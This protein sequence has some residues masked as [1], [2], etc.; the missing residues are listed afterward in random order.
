MHD[1][2]AQLEEPATFYD[3]FLPLCD[4]RDY[5]SGSHHAENLQK[6]HTFPAPTFSYVPS[7]P[8]S[9]SGH[10][11]AT[12]T[13]TSATAAVLDSTAFRNPDAS[14][15]PTKRLEKRPLMV[16]PDHD[17]I[18]V[19]NEQLGHSRMPSWTNISSLPATPI[20]T[21]T[22]DFAGN[23]SR[24]QYPATTTRR[25]NTHEFQPVQQLYG[26]PAI[27]MPKSMPQN[28]DSRNFAMQQRRLAVRNLQHARMER[29]NGGIGD[30][31]AAYSLTSYGSENL[32]SHNQ[33]QDFNLEHTNVSHSRRNSRRSGSGSGASLSGS[34][35]PGS[36]NGLPFSSS[37]SSFTSAEVGESGT[38][39]TSANGSS[40]ATPLLSNKPSLGSI[41]AAVSGTI[42]SERKEKQKVLAPSINN[43][44]GRMTNPF[45]S[46]STS[47]ATSSSISTLP[48]ITTAPTSTSML[49][50]STSP[51]TTT[52]TTITDDN[53]VM[54]KFAGLGISDNND[55][56]AVALSPTTSAMSPFDPINR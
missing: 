20:T 45:A 38:R 14:A 28:E 52:M 43:H 13:V 19:T 16:D 54:T 10:S 30:N 39:F 24:S 44:V 27:D 23:S 8:M 26:P 17:D 35:T 55:H 48:T 34:I 11:T 40:C 51:T 37:E 56:A 1:A 5:H 22:R 15:S 12:Q 32:G 3:D 25:H 31:S 33:S 49:S 29:R 21:M 47:F 50:S 41:R 42:G 4:I 6:Q 7:R 46:S 9:P 36:E 2:I 18:N 53:E